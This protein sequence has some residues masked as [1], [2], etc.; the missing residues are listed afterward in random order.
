MHFDEYH[1][2]KWARNLSYARRLLRE[3]D[4]ETFYGGTDLPEGDVYPG[5][6]V[7]AAYWVSVEHEMKLRLRL[8]L[9]GAGH[10]EWRD[11]PELCAQ[12]DEFSVRFLDDMR[13]LAAREDIVPPQHIDELLARGIETPEAWAEQ[14]GA[15]QEASEA[16]LA[17]GALPDELVESWFD[18][19][20]RS[21][22]NYNRYLV[23]GGVVAAAQLR[24]E[25]EAALRAAV[26]A[27]EDEFMWAVSGW[28]N[29]TACRRWRWAMP[30]VAIARCTAR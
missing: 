18:S 16:A 12:R 22:A 28:P 24:R 30:S 25:G 17:Q 9:Q 7:M 2:H 27:T 20:L 19:C 10:P 15:W 29:G 23:W 14:M 11:D 13:E 6:R 5:M 21:I 4:V 8:L 26:T 3:G 1:N